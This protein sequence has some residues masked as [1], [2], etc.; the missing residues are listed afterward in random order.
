[1]N[2]NVKIGDVIY[3]RNITSLDEWDV[4]LI[5]KTTVKN[6]DAY[7][8]IT[9]NNKY[10]YFDDNRFFFTLQEAKES[11]KQWVEQQQ[12]YLDEIEQDLQNY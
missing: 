9:A 5:C 3:Y 10:L 12:K 7:R 8:V 11:I 2:S 6:V 1:M 4:N